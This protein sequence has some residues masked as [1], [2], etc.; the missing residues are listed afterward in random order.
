M[1]IRLAILS[2]CGKY[3]Y[4]LFRQWANSEQMPVMWLMLNPSTADANID[5]ATIRRCMEFSKRWGYGSMFVGNIYAWRSTDP[6]GL[7]LSDDPEGPENRGHLQ[8]MASSSDKVI[9]A[10]GNHG[11]AAGNE[12]LDLILPRTHGGY[13]H[14]GK[15]NRGQPKHPLARGK[16]F[17]PYETQ[18]QEYR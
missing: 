6:R 14:L 2:E 12:Y 8:A 10:W 3:R 16:S 11:A 7:G 15:T 17:I 9:A 4:R 18:L 13:W 5:D 1:M